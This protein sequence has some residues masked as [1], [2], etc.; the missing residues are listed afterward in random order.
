MR[1]VTC[2]PTDLA[3]R[4]FAYMV[5]TESADEKVFVSN[6]VVREAYF[7]LILHILCKHAPRLAHT[8]Y[9]CYFYT[10]GM[11]CCGEHLSY[12]LANESALLP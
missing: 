12:L 5:E 7:T 1:L 4:A 8:I 3:T 10:S 2:Q 11:Y 9:L 6:R